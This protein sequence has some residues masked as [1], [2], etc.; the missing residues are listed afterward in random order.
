MRTIS[1]A[2]SGVAILLLVACGPAPITPSTP[3]ETGSLS[4]TGGGAPAEVADAGSPAP[5]E[6]LGTG[7]GGG[8]DSPAARPTV[9]SNRP[10]SGSR[11]APINSTLSATFSAALDPATVNSTTFTVMSG[12]HLLAGT[13]SVSGKTA[14]FAPNEVLPENSVLTGVVSTGVKDTTGRAL[15]EDYSWTFHTGT[16]Q[17]A[18]AV[19]STFPGVWAAAVDPRSPVS[20]T[21]ST[22][23]N[24]GA[25]QGTFVVTSNGHPVAGFGSYSGGTATFVPAEPLPAQS[26]VEVTVKTGAPIDYSWKFSVAQ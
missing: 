5:F 24:L 20:A 18:P 10:A 12:T 4:G 7:T 2:I 13:V 19:V 21:F 11:G 3:M 17:E 23:L 16:A 1:S 9:V 22:T 25:L 6:A 14:T 15:Y 26:T 8:G